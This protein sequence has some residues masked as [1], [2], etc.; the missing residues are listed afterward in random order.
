[1]SSQEMEQYTSINNENKKLLEDSKDELGASGMEPETE[2]DAASLVTG[3]SNMAQEASWM[4]SETQT[5]TDAAASVTVHVSNMAP[6][7][8]DEAQ[9]LEYELYLAATKDDLKSFVLVFERVL[10]S[11]DNPFNHARISDNTLLHVATENGCARIARLI[12]QRFPFLMAQKN[13]SGDTPFH[14]VTRDGDNSVFKALIDIHTEYIKS[15]PSNDEESDRSDGALQVQNIKGNTALHEAL[16]HRRKSMARH[17]AKICRKHEAFVLN[18]ENKS[19]VYLALEAGYK[20]CVKILLAE[21]ANDDQSLQKKASNGESVLHAAAKGQNL[22]ILVMI[23]SKLP[24][25]MNLDDN[26]GMLPIHWAASAGHLKGVRHLLTYNS[27]HFTRKDANG[28]LPIHHASMKGHVDV[29]HELLKRIYDPSQHLNKKGNNILHLAA[30]S[31]KCNVVNYI[32]KHVWSK[33]LVNQK[34]NDGNTP[35]HLASLHSHPHIISAL[36]WD[37]RTQVKL[38]NNEGRTALDVALQNMNNHI[39]LRQ[40][41][42]W[43]ALKAAKTPTSS[44]SNQPEIMF[45]DRVNSLQV[46]AALVATVTFAAGFTMP[47]GYNSSEPDVGMPVM[48][49]NMKF[50]FFVFFNTIAMYAA[51]LVIVILIWAQLGAVHIVMA[52]LEWAVPLLG[53]ALTMMCVAYL[54]GVYTVVSKLNWLANAVLISGCIILVTIAVLFFSLL[55]PIVSGNRTFRFFAYYLI[56]LMLWITNSYSKSEDEEGPS[57]LEGEPRNRNM[58]AKL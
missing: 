37:K 23:T 25:L 4:E 55:L 17:L 19:A 5:Q 36:T 22:D 50:Q 32:L 6:E 48:L 57:A 31:G 28:L 47:G 29:V 12:A 21:A 34:D 38:L 35:L 46:V 1:M 51:T 27:L 49:N 40:K 45:T 2:T 18:N 54:S 24:S 41:L 7:L 20:K 13:S 8:S 11:P 44:N 39:S 30:K 10:T 3:H 58:F 52:S 42:T 56:C 15:L 14:I 16:I 53:G 43:A 9:S 33:K 26:K